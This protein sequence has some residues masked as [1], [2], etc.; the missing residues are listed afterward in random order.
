MP[1]SVNHH[2]STRAFC[3]SCG[4]YIGAHI[5]CEACGKEN[6]PEATFCAECGIELHDAGQIVS[7]V[8]DRTATE[9]RRCECG[10]VQTPTWEYH[11]AIHGLFAKGVAET[12]KV[13][14]WKC[15]S[16]GHKYKHEKSIEEDNKRIEEKKEEERKTMRSCGIAIGV[17]VLFIVLA[18]HIMC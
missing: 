1:S 3:I 2:L 17:F 4:V 11:S 7:N 13:L 9:T 6:D 16:C 18:Y 8:E 15:G 14:W 12:G 10:G 5:Q